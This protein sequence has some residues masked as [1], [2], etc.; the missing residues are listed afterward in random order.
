MGAEEARLAL[1]EQTAQVDA[2]VEAM[3]PPG[4]A[5]VA[6]ALPNMPRVLALT[7]VPTPT[8]AT[9]SPSAE[10]PRYVDVTSVAKVFRIGHLEP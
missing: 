2:A 6:A 1:G 7:P 5:T 9:P 4:G 8:E 10:G 3:S